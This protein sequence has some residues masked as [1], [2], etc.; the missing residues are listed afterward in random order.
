MTRTERITGIALACLLLFMTLNSTYYFLL[1]AKVNV[2][3]WIVFNA[4]A[5]ASIA[6]LVGLLLFWKNKNKMW[7]LIATVPLFF[8]GTT[9]LFVFPWSGVYCMAQVAHITMTLNLLWSIW[10]VWKNKDYKAMGNGLLISI[11][12]FI[13]F[14]AFTQAFCREHANEVMR[15]LGI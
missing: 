12:L 7:L 8:F 10:M 2:V 4:C 13:P 1:I 11:G 15:I 5:P 9:G 3:Q 6:Y 14:I